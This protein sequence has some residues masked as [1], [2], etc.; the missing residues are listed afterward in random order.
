M[1]VCPSNITATVIFHG[2]N[3][4]TTYATSFGGVARS[5]SSSGN[6]RLSRTRRAADVATDADQPRF[7]PPSRSAAFPGGNGGQLVA[8]STTDTSTAAKC[9]SSRRHEEP[10]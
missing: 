8:E 10:A 9:V 4:E 5:L 1:L 7:D 3:H 2:Y 6:R